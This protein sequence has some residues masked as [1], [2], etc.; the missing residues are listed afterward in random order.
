MA[1]DILVRI[2]HWSIAC[3]FLVNYWLFEAGEDLHE[4]AGYALLAVLT[5]RLVWGFIGPANA[6][7]SDFFP[8]LSRLKAAVIYFDQEHKALQQSLQKPPRHAGLAGAMVVFLWAG[9]LI[10]GISGWLQETDQ[11]WG[12]DWVQLLHEW[13][14]DIVMIAVTFHV[15]AVLLIQWK[16]RLPLIRNMIR[17]HL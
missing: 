14:A 9:L 17:D 4:W 1:W 7:F 12:E 8:T 2:T 3:L 11:F 16:Y 6:R 5:V 10:V 13:S 15:A